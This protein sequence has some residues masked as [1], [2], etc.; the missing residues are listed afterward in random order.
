MPTLDNLRKEI[1]EVDNAMFGLFTYRMKIA[2][3]IARLKLLQGK[4]VVDAEREAFLLEA[5]AARVPPDLAEEARMLQACLI[6]L[7]RDYQN[8]LMGMQSNPMTN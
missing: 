4:P 3:E 7:S 2:A 1:D 5:S 8:R 6:Q